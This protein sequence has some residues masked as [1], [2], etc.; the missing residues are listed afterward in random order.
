M[1]SQTKLLR[2]LI[3]TALAMIG[4]FAFASV[5]QADTYTVTKEAD[6]ADGTCD[7]DCSLREAVIQANSTAADDNIVLN[8]GHY[9]LTIPGTEEDQAADGDLDLLDNGS[10]TIKGT[11]ARDTIIDGLGVADTDNN[12]ESERVFDVYARASISNVTVQGGSQGGSGG[13]IRIQGLRGQEVVP[14]GF[15]APASLSLDN[16]SVS[17]N[18]AS[19]SGG[20]IAN[21]AGDLTISHSLLRNNY[22]ESDGGAVVS[23]DGGTTHIENSTIQD[24]TAD[25]ND[26]C[27]GVG[28]VTGFG[29]TTTL[30]NDTIVDNTNLDGSCSTDP[31]AGLASDDVQSDGVPSPETSSMTVQ[32]TIVA[33]NRTLGPVESTETF[34]VGG[35]PELNNCSGTTLTSGGYNIEDGTDCGF[36]NTG[37][38]QS[39]DPKLGALDNNGGQTDTRALLEGS[40]AINTAGSGAPADDQRGVSRPQGAASDIGAFEV[41][42]PAPPVPQP[43]TPQQAKPG[44]PTIAVAGVRRACTSSSSVSVKVKATIASG[45]TLKEVRVSLDGKRIATRTKGSFTLKVNAKKLKAGR[46][47]LR[48]T[49][50]DSAGQSKT[51]TKVL[52]R[53][54]QAKPKA[55]VQP[56]FTG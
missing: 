16:T 55:K 54:A 3:A 5:A 31:S 50:I 42:V 30:L 38:L 49:V 48:V 46:H 8:P 34:D 35:T 51:S 13:G 32:N 56:R 47:R 40:P 14:G 9:T 44:A 15:S 24:N 33:N 39:T 45:A 27:A 53:C 41:E 37:D 6:T 7:S 20:G 23:Y 4:V 36:T 43:V 10:I 11:S 26:G 12:F 2:T 29:S 28:A 25:S 21:Q 19:G 18:E 1:G 17:D 22:A 52:A